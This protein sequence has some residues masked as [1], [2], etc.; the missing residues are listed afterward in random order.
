MYGPVPPI[1]VT[2]ELP[3]FPPKQET[4]T[5]DTIDAVGEPALTI[6][7]VDVMEQPLASVIVQ[8]YEPAAN[9]VAVAAFPPEGAHE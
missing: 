3:L 8:V 1:V 7:T 4:F 9:P 5:E 6:V 2:V